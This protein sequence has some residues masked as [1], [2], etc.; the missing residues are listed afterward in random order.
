MTTNT[1]AT[2]IARTKRRRSALGAAMVEAG[3][4]FP[5]MAMFMSLFEAT[6]HSYDGYI[7]AQHVARERAWSGATQG[8]FILSCP[9][10]RD[11]TSYKPSYFTM[12]KNVKG[13]STG[14]STTQASNDT[15]VPVSGPGGWGIYHASAQAEAKGKR[16]S[17][18]FD[19]KP[20]SN[21]HIFCNQSWVGGLTDIF[22]S[23]LGIGKSK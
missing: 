12:D 11:D 2:R 1:K 3:I 14:G 17:I 23:A 9:T 7:S 19:N 6:H 20:T 18:A 16:G 13:T 15:G 21:S 8:S 5:I 4:I 22:K 10:G